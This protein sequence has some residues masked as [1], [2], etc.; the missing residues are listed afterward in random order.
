[1]R[2]HETSTSLAGI[3]ALR[4]PTT[5]E[6]VGK[7]ARRGSRPD[8][9]QVHVYVRQDLVRRTKRMTASRHDMHEPGTYLEP[10]GPFTITE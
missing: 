1:M 6:E 8:R 2:D 4:E 3:L 10:I 9:F 7:G 5:G